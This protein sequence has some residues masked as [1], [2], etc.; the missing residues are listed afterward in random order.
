MSTPI[1]SGGPAMPFF[2]ESDD[3]KE[4]TLRDYFMAHAPNIPD[5][6]ERKSDGKQQ[7]IIPAPEIGE[8]WVKLKDKEWV[9]DNLAHLVRWRITYADAMLAAREEVTK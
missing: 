6:F 1:N 3:S 9:E 8:S 7:V 2:K 4:M 5:F